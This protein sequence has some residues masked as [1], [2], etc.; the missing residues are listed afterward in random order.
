MYPSWQ[1]RVTGVLAVVTLSVLGAAG[2]AADASS[3]PAPATPL[4]RPSPLPLAVPALDWQPCPDAADDGEDGDEL[5]C[6]T[7]PVPLDHA[8]PAAGTIELA[9]VRR[10]ARDPAQRI[11]SLLWLEGGPGVSGVETIRTYPDLF[12]D[13]IR[14]RFD[15][16]G[17]DQRGV[18]ESAPVRCLADEQKDV[19]LLGVDAP[20][21]GRGGGATASGGADRLTAAEFAAS[22]AAEREVAEGCERMSGW[23]LPYLST[24][25]AARDVDL[26]RAALGE[27]RLT[28]FGGSYGTQLGLTYAALFPTRLRALVLDSVVDPEMALNRPFEETRMQAA[29]FEAALNAFLADCA[30]DP[31]CLFGGGDPAGAYDRLMARLAE[32][33]IEATGKEL[34]PGPH[35]VDDT[36]ARSAIIELLYSQELWPTLDLVLALADEFDDGSAMLALAQEQAGRRDDGTYDNSFD[37]NNAINC[38]DQAYPRDVAAYRRLSDEL[39]AEYP[40]IGSS[41]AL[42]GLSCAFWPQRAASRYTGPFTAEGAPPILVIGTTGDPAT[43]YPEAVSVARRLSN[44]E[45]LTWRSYTHGAYTGP[46]T[47]VH[48][49]VNRYLIDLELPKPGTVCE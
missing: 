18:G 42:G 17:F 4:P 43:P 7:L 41:V 14:D 36:V 34:G 6:A 30:A 44:S 25:A 24:E 15:I 38:A 47:C 3:R 9:L 21:A 31:D 39:A 27:H 11:G 33:P 1:A 13:P 48:D 22:V 12:D 5:E 16:V 10:P 40:R 28:A 46:S 8:R 37:A 26:I 19:L 29:A 45:L 23:L 35:L 2:P 20:G 32:D 49:I